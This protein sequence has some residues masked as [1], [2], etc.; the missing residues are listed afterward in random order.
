MDKII[1]IHRRQWE[2]FSKIDEVEFDYYFMKYDRDGHERPSD[3]SL[4]VYVRMKY[5]YGYEL[6]GRRLNTN[7]KIE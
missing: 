2:Q 1:A 7:E 6:V 3:F 5:G 4:D